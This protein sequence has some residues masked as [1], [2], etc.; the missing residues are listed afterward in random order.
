[1]S[2][3]PAF[4]LGEITGVC[5]SY[6]TELFGVDFSTHLV[7]GLAWIVTFFTALLIGFIHYQFTG[8]QA[9]KTQQNFM[10][11]AVVSQEESGNAS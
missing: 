4:I 5:A 2:V 9:S 11:R 3:I 6:S 1:V 10:W 7:I 8:E